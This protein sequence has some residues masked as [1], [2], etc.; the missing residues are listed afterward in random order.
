MFHSS[1]APTAQEPAICPDVYTQHLDD[2]TDIWG[3][4]LLFWLAKTTMTKNKTWTRWWNMPPQVPENKQKTKRI[5]NRSKCVI[6]VKGIVNNCP[7]W[8]KIGFAIYNIL[9][10][11]KGSDGWDIN[12]IHTYKY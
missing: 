5:C 11:A 4:E 8:M 12:T 6:S 2:L 9:S 1:Q 7:V 10:F 3:R